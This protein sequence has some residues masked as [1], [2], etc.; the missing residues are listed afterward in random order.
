MWYTYFYADQTF[1]H[2][3]QN[4]SKKKNMKKEKV[5]KGGVQSLEIF[6]E[7]SLAQR[8]RHFYAFEM[9]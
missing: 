7:K 6:E 9:C 3:K 8:T 5:K 1:I 4:K 2:I